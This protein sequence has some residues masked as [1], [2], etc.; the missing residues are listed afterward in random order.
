M[1]DNDPRLRLVR[2][3]NQG[4]GAA[5]NAGKRSRLTGTRVPAASASTAT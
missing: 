5:R 2:Q 1:V 3:S 4:E